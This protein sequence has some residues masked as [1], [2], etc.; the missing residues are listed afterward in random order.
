M[1]FYRSVLFVCLFVCL[2]LLFFFG[3]G[4]RRGGEGKYFLAIKLLF[5][6]SF[7]GK[8]NV[9]PF[10]RLMTVDA[11]LRQ[12]R[13]YSQHKFA[14][15]KISYLLPWQLPDGTRRTSQEFCG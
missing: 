12:L 11:N 4:L 15:T 7:G 14:S 1:V 10:N 9:L 13:W 2:L 3:G 8:Y 6:N 5:C